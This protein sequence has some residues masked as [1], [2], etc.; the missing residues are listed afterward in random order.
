MFQVTIYE[1]KCGFAIKGISHVRMSISFIARPCQALSHPRHTR[2]CSLLNTENETILNHKISEFRNILNE[3]SE[4]DLTFIQ[5]IA[6]NRFK[7]RV[8]CA[9]IV[10]QLLICYEIRGRKITKCGW[11]EYLQN[12]LTLSFRAAQNL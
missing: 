3:N 5:S 7:R 10:A 1:W 8:C 4:S 12:S 6:S 9:I 11:I 2:I